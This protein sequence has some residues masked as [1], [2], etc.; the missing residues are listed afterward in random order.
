MR[1]ITDSDAF[2]IGKH[3]TANGVSKPSTL[4]LSI[5]NQAF[6]LGKLYWNR[7]RGS[8]LNETKTITPFI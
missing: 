4:L 1:S 2:P 5:C 3:A 6:L 7:S 8:Y